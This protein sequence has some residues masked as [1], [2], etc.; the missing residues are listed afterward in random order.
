[1]EI[2]ECTGSWLHFRGRVGGGERE[3][4][5]TAERNTHKEK[6]EREKRVRMRETVGESAKER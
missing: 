4:E 2:S 3:E 1:M 5:R 6:M